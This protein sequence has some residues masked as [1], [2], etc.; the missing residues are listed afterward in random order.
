MTRAPLCV[1]VRSV[2]AGGGDGRFERAPRVRGRRVGDHALELAALHQ[3][4]PVV[5]L[6]HVVARKCPLA[7]E[8]VDE[9]DVIADL[10]AVLRLHPRLIE[11]AVER[12]Q[13][14]LHVSLPYVCLGIRV[15]IARVPLDVRVQ[16]VDA[17]VD[18]TAVEGLYEPQANGY[19]ML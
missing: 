1:K 4:D 12:L 11:M 5:A 18:V 17:G 8:P 15:A 9:H 16:Q 10:V 2:T 7:A 6:H 14:P 3:G 13:I 19:E